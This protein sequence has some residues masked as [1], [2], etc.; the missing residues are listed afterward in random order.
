MYGMI[1]KGAR[2]A[3]IKV[4]GEEAWE[5]SLSVSGLSE[6]HLISAAHYDDVMTYSLIEAISLQC[7]MTLNEVLRAAGRHWVEY[8]IAAGYGDIIALT[9][10]NLVEFIENLDRMHESLNRTLPKAVLPSFQ[11]ISA[12]PNRLEVIYKSQ[13]D[14]LE[15]LVLGI[16]EGVLE[17]FDEQM[18]IGYTVTEEETYFTLIRVQ[19]PVASHG[20][21]KPILDMAV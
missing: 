1:H 19:C 7:N 8:T 20:K 15:E 14:G 13:R 5:K 3:V 21:A 12:T 10:R 17:Y 11:L 16:F 18:E 4:F 6:E 2:H 9:G